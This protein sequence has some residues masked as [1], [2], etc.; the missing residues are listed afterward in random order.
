M[1]DK[2]DWRLQGQERYLEGVTLFHR[3]YRRNL[4]DPSWDHDHCEFCWAKFMVKDYAEVLHEGYTTEDDYH[5]ICGECF[6]DFKDTFGWKVV[7]CL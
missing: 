2:S 5:W 7:E 6:R 4:K 1:I 3:Q